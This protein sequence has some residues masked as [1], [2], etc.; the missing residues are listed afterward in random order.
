M[1]R[2]EPQ[3]CVELLR[4]VHIVLEPFRHRGQRSGLTRQR[5]DALI[6]LL[7]RHLVLRI[8]RDHAAAVAACVD[9]VDHREVVGD[10][11]RGVAGE[12]GRRA[13]R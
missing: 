6:R 3:A 10:G 5:H 11:L 8:E 4:V 1:R 7:A 12:L 2:R 9:E 13:H